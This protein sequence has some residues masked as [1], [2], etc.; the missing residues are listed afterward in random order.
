M[1]SYPR[2]RM[3]GDNCLELKKRVTKPPRGDFLR[4]VVTW[5]LFPCMWVVGPLIRNA[6]RWLLAQYLLLWPSSL[7][8]NPWG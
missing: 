4:Q 3:D 6:Y 8:E 1:L 5:V 2:R 7:G